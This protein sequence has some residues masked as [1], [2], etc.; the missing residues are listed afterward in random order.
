MFM[1]NV[2]LQKRSIQ[3]KG[4]NDFCLP[5]DFIEKQRAYF[6]EVD[7]FELPVEEI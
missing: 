6:E 4:A 1:D 7:K 3:Q 2:V 5:R